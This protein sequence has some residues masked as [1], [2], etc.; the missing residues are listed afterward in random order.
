MAGRRGN[1]EG[2]I[3]QR[4]DG[5]WVGA[6]TKSPGKR[7][8]IYASTRKEIHDQITDLLKAQKDGLPLPGKRQPIAQYLERWLDESARHRLRPTTFIRYQ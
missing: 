7:S 5:R 8:V 3:Y 2:S 1:R 6:L 4:K